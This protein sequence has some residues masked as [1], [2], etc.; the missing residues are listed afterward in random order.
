MA[1]TTVV[2]MCT[3][4]TVRIIACIH[5][6]YQT[7]NIGLVGHRSYGQTRY[8]ST[9]SCHYESNLKPGHSLVC[10][11]ILH[12]ICVWVYMWIWNCDYSIEIM[13][14]TIIHRSARNTKAC[15]GKKEKALQVLFMLQR[16]QLTIK[17]FM[18]EGV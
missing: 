9:V 10:Q 18:H 1:N 13:S 17:M 11:H 16:A 6:S 5:M 12:T 15:V 4:H 14:I 8:R 3:V 2:Y 7:R